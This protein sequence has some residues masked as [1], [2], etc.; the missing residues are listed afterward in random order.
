MPVK[1]RKLPRQNKW[2]VYNGK[3]VVAKA[4]SKSNAQKQVRL[5]RGVAHGMKLKRNI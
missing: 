2:R 3:E 1:M 4:T 5:L